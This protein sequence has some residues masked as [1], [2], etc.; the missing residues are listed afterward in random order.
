VT[1]V[2]LRFSRSVSNESGPTTARPSWGAARRHLRTFRGR[3]SRS[4]AGPTAH[5][6]AWSRGRRSPLRG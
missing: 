6:R 5:P 2:T 3:A 4:G 1:A